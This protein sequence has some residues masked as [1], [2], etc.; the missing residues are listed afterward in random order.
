[1]LLTSH[2]DY[3]GHSRVPLFNCAHHL[4]QAKLILIYSKKKKKKS[5]PQKGH[6]KVHTEVE[7]NVAVFVP[8]LP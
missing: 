7:R 1:M 8:P 6:T 5:F 2:T 3:I 4:K